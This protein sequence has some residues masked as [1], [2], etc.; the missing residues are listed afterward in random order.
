MTAITIGKKREYWV[1]FNVE[2]GGKAISGIRVEISR[3]MEKDINSKFAINLCDD[4]LYPAL[5]RYVMDNPPKG[6]LQ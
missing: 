1:N 4:P 5:H 3:A 2:N 6:E